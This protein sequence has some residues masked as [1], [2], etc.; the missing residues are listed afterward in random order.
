MVLLFKIGTTLCTWQ[1]QVLYRS[2]F[3]EEG[4]ELSE[5]PVRFVKTEHKK[6]WRAEG[7][8]KDSGRS[9]SAG[10][11]KVSTHLDQYCVT[12]VELFGGIGPGLA[13]ALEA[14][15]RVKKWVYVELDPEVRRMAWK[16]AQMLQQWYPAQLTK[17]VLQEAMQNKKWDMGQI[18]KEDVDSWGKVDLL[19]AGWECQGT[20][21]AGKGK[22]LQDER[23]AMVTK[24]LTIM[25]WA[26]EV[27]GEYAYILEHVDMRSDVREPVRAVRELVEAE[28]GRGVSCDVAYA[29]AR[30]FIEMDGI[31]GP[32]MVYDHQKKRWEEPT[33]LERELAMGYLPG[34]TATEGVEEEVRRAALGR[35]IDQHSLRW[36]I[37][38]MRKGAVDRGGRAGKEQ[39]QGNKQVA[40]AAVG[41]VTGGKESDT[42]PAGGKEAEQGKE[43]ELGADIGEQTAEAV[44]EL[45]LTTDLPTY[46]RRRRMNAEDA[47]ICK[48][49]C[50][51]LLAAG[52]IRPSESSYAAA[53]MIAARKDITG[54]VLAKRMCGDFWELNKITSPDRYPMP[55]AEDIFDCLE[56]AI[57]F[58]TLDLRQGFNQLAIREEDKRK[59]AFHEVDGLYEY[60]IMPFGIRNAPAAM[61][62][63]LKGIPTAACYIDD[64]LI[65]SSSEEQHVRDLKQTLEAV[66][67]AGLTCHPKKCKIARHT[68]ARQ[69]LVERAE[70]SGQGSVVEGGVVVNTE[71]KVEDQA[72]ERSAAPGEGGAAV[73][74]GGVSAT[75]PHPAAPAAPAPPA[76]PAAAATSAASSAAG[77]VPVISDPAVAVFTFRAA[78]LLQWVRVHGPR[79]NPPSYCTRTNPEAPVLVL[80]HPV[81]DLPSLLVRFG[82]IPKH[83]GTAGSEGSAMKE[84]GVGGGVPGWEEFPVGD[85]EA[86]KAHSRGSALG[87]RERVEGIGGVEEG[88][89]GLAS[90]EFLGLNTFQTGSFRDSVFDRDEMLKEFNVGSAKGQQERG[91]A[92]SP[93][94]D[95]Q[96]YRAA[97]ALSDSSTHTPAFPTVADRVEDFL[98]GFSPKRQAKEGRGG[99]LAR[100]ITDWVLRL[101]LVATETS[102]SSGSSSTTS[103]TSGAAKGER[104]DMSWVALALGAYSPGKLKPMLRSP[105]EVDAFTEFMVGTT[106]LTPACNCCSLC[107]NVSNRAVTPAAVVASFAFRP[108]SVLLRCILSLYPQRFTPTWSRLGSWLLFLK[109][110]WSTS[111]CTSSTQRHVSLSLGITLNDIMAPRPSPL[112]CSLL[113]CLP[114]PPTPHSDE[115]APRHARD[116]PLPDL[117]PNRLVAP[118]LEGMLEH[119]RLHFLYTAA[120]LLS[121]E[122]IVQDIMELHRADG[123]I[124]SE[125]EF[126]EVEW[127]GWEGGEE[128]LMWEEVDSWRN[129][130]LRAWPVTDMYEAPHSWAAT[131]EDERVRDC[132]VGMRRREREYEEISRGK[133]WDLV[134]RM[135]AAAG[136]GAAG[137]T[138][139]E[140]ES[141]VG[142][143]LKMAPAYL[144]PWVGGVNPFACL[145]EMLLGETCYWELSDGRRVGVTPGAGAGAGEARGAVAAEGLRCCA[146]PECG[147]AEGPG[148]PPLNLA[149]GAA[150]QHTATGTA[151][152]PTGR[153]FLSYSSPYVCSAPTLFLPSSFLNPS[154]LLFPPFSPVLS[155]PP[156]CPVPRVGSILRIVPFPQSMNQTH[157]RQ[158][159]SVLPSALLPHTTQFLAWAASHGL[160]LSPKTRIKLT[161]DIPPEPLES[162]TD[163][164]ATKTKTTS[165]S[166]SSGG[167]AG[168][169]GKGGSKKGEKGGK[170]GKGESG[171]SGM[172]RLVRGLVAEADMESGDTLCK[173][174]VSATTQVGDAEGTRGGVA[175]VGGAGG[176]KGGGSMRERM[177]EMR[178][179][180]LQ[181]RAAAKAGI[182]G[183]G[184]KQLGWDLVALRILEEK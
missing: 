166:S 62:Q 65:F 9:G 73:P 128:W 123:V 95:V 91:I 38:E 106:T 92:T 74:A 2:D 39:G 148:R 139:S 163:S 45:N 164:P 86:L 60:N 76:P 121:R 8:R 138:A 80:P 93:A 171:G 122:G 57:I 56:G 101:H 83:V 107:L 98:R 58:T 51:E 31:P 118:L 22:G 46:Q 137:A 161:P 154:P 145:R 32:G 1:E 113:P 52:I 17:E 3:W 103:S 108:S 24:L 156:A 75:Y 37:K 142:G 55:T 19:V 29:R 100:A 89:V 4:K 6:A 159:P 136:A 174:P 141:E 12:L 152:R 127:N 64:I 69:R 54:K 71:K 134:D 133:E 117:V 126:R 181:G 14:G 178:Q 33:A 105:R 61:D 82:A 110:W 90:G 13:T 135:V 99:P 119:K 177:M 5:L 102:S 115:R 150:R 96:E 41:K 125:E 153:V 168:G 97:K 167:G 40:Y 21:R 111:A 169:G 158:S 112:P 109:A 66:A 182:G 25:K 94:E 30:G 157:T 155:C 104:Q 7:L 151:R 10:K 144:V 49:K 179:R 162:A 53:I 184:R 36:L 67:A 120:I 27:N 172:V 35:A 180:V 175:V 15:L 143:G 131:G 84:F 26:R 47:A 11:S 170:G 63:V 34:A 114:L 130:V 88:I 59:T 72:S 43:W 20:S 147:R 48:E 50:E 173:I 70:E 160:Y 44:R 78:Y 42:A 85:R 81:H 116:P 176:A 129:V 140:A 79:L 18:T 124:R 23:T 77:L 87:G 146:F 165:R 183:G 149:R 68:A 16:H 28:L 132:C